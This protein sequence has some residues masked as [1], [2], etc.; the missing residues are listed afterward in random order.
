MRLTSLRA[1]AAI[2][3]SAG[4]HMRRWNFVAA[5]LQ[6]ELEQDEVVYFHAPPGYATTGADGR[7]RICRIEKPIF[8]MAQA[9]RRW[10]RSLFPWLLDFGFTQCASD[11]CVFT[12]TKVINKVEQRLTLGCYVD[13]LFTL[14]SHDATGSLYDEFVQALTLRW[15][16]EDEGP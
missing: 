7:P 11:P 14:Y 4:M 1:L 15:N 9:G 8:G 10:Q 13:D 5:Y 2:A 6:G 16:V 3:N 12:M